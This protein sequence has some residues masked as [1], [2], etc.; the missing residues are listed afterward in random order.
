MASNPGKAVD[1]GELRE[2]DDGVS[3]AMTSRRLGKPEW[4]T[5]LLARI[6]V[7]GWDS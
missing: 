7:S 6:S 1:V 3:A 5:E 2:R 4:D